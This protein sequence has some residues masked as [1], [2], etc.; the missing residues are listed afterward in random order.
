MPTVLQ[1]AREYR[2]KL[3]ELEAETAAEIIRYYQRALEEVLRDLAALTQQIQ[4]AKK[5]G[6]PISVAKL[7]R[8]DRYKTLLATIA[9]E[10]GKFSGFAAERITMGQTRALE[11]GQSGAKE[12]VMRPRPD[13][14]V[15]YTW[16]RVPTQAVENIAGFLS[17]GSPLSSILNGLG[18]DAASRAKQVLTSAVITGKNPRQTAQKMKGAFGGNLSRALTVARTEQLRAYRTATVESYRANSEVVEGWIRLETLDDL[19]CIICIEEHGRFYTNESDFETH[20]NCRGT[21]IPKVI[22]VDREM[23]TGPEWFARQPEDRQREILGKD[24]HEAYKAGD[25]TL[26][27]LNQRT[28]S[29]DWG[30]GRRERTLDEAKEHARESFGPT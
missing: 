16:D 13:A 18:A 11:L 24:K 15:G 4:D 12:M 26:S 10:I 22:G 23:E 7:K 25:I 8:E 3:R 28:Y 21:L 1:I 27:D 2:K 20:P 29:D 17:N 5:A 14:I 19:T 6:K 9:E 30:G